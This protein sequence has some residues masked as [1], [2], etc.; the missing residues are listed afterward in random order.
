MQL[1]L[2]LMYGK[3]PPFFISELKSNLHWITEKCCISKF[4][5]HYEKGDFL[6][7]IFFM[8]DIHHCFICRPSDSTVSEDA[9]IEPRTVATTAL[10]VRRSDHS[11]KSHPIYMYILIT[12]LLLI[13]VLRSFIRSVKAVWKISSSDSTDLLCWNK[14]AKSYPK[15]FRTS[16]FYSFLGSLAPPRDPYNWGPL[17]GRNAGPKKGRNESEHSAIMVELFPPLIYSSPK[18]RFSALLR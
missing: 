6:G 5:V 12:V 10:N 15:R 2:F 9:E 8:Y 16:T 1:N 18:C 11:A 14:R 17:K 7:Y 4:L 3:I 13:Y